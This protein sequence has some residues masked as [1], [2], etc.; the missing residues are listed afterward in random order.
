MNKTYAR[1]SRLLGD[2]S[3]NTIWRIHQNIEVISF[4]NERISVYV[5]EKKN[6]RQFYKTS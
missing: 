4:I 1:F 5:T 3:G 6:I 2:H